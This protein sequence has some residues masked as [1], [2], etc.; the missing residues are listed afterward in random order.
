MPKIRFHTHLGSCLKTHP[1]Y[2][3]ANRKQNFVTIQMSSE[4][5]GFSSSQSLWAI[6]HGNKS[7]HACPFLS[8]ISII[9]KKGPITPLSTTAS[10]QMINTSVTA[11]YK[12]WLWKYVLAWKAH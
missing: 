4:Q 11:L 12:R 2:S 6:I 9:Y 10:N 5:R 1:C 7:F 3:E 8:G